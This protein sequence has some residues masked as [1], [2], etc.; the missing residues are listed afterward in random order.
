VE[1]DRA[2]IEWSAETRLEDGGT[3]RLAGVSLLRFDPD[4]LVIEQRDFW[5]EGS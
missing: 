3:E 5:A 1:D 2:A 4:G